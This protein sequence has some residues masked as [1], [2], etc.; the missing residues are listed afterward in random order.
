MSNIQKVIYKI[1]IKN[2]V[3]LGGKGDE[4]NELDSHVAKEAQA[5]K[6]KT[7]YFWKLLAVTLELKKKKISQAVEHS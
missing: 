1:G 5:Y 2:G 3:I 7:S 6:V 4:A